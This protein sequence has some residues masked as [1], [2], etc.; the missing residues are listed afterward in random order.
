[1]CIRDRCSIA[2]IRKAAGRDAFANFDVD[3][4][5]QVKHAAA[6]SLGSLEYELVRV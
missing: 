2:L 3:P 4:E 6:L 5:I 1:M